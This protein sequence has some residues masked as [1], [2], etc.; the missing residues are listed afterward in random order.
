MIS[1]TRKDALDRLATFIENG[2]N[3]Y[4]LERNYD[5]GPTNRSN[6]SILSPFIKKRI[7]HECEV[8]KECLKFKKFENIEKFVQEVFGEHIGK[9][10]LKVEMKYGKNTK[11]HY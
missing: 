11:N 2:L 10:G 9:V 3:K 4:S 6:V 1:D 8:L 5:F 7:I